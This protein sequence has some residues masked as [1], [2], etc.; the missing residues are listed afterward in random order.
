MN[1]THTFNL[2]K[3]GK[4]LDE[5][6]N[7]IIMLHGR[8]G[9]AKDLVH[10]LHNHL[11]LDG[12]AILAPQASNHTW[13]PYSFMAPQMQNEP[14]LSSALNIV[15][16]TVDTAL[17]GGKTTRN[18]FFL[19]FSQGACLMLEYVARHAAAYKGIFAYTGGLIGDKIYPENYAG[20]FHN[21]PVLLGCSDVDP[22]VPL[23][24]VYA[25]ENIL[26]D[27]GAEVHLRVYPDMG[28]TINGDEIE[29]TNRILSGEQQGEEPIK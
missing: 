17:A 18:L 7:V 12:M 16:Q 6:E 15:Q 1:N 21:T 29:L 24:R 27:R 26:K 8:G 13:Y 14:W 3:S 25:S 11:S 10:S 2:E 22:H 4:P 20:N 5:A 19:G 9:D 23:Q 28:H